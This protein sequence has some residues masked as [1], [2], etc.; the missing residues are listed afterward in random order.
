MSSPVWRAMSSELPNRCTSPSPA[1]IA[2]EVT[3]PTPN[4]EARSDRQL[5]VP[6]TRPNRG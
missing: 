5:P 6:D 2:T 3:V 4:W 1:H